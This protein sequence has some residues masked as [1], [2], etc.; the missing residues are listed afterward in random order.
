[1]MFMFISCNEHQ[2]DEE[3]LNSEKIVA[4]NENTDG[5]MK[6][7]S[8]T[9]FPRFN[10]TEYCKAE[11]QEMVYEEMGEFGKENPY[12]LKTEFEGKRMYISYA[13]IDDCCQDFRA[14][15]TLESDK[16]MLYHLNYSGEVCECKCKYVMTF[17]INGLDSI[18]KELYIN[19]ERIDNYEL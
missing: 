1:M 5:D 14:K 13:Y 19:K 2:Q 9:L 3:I 12:N 16:L 18:P 17:E 10:T 7:R 6:M 15:A 4:I 11:D 8:K